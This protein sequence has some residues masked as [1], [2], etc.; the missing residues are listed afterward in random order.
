[1][2]NHLALCNVLPQSHSKGKRRCMYQ[3]VWTI[4]GGWLLAWHQRHQVHLSKIANSW[5]MVRSCNAMRVVRNRR[6]IRFKRGRYWALNYNQTMHIFTC[7]LSICTHPPAHNYNR[8]INIFIHAPTCYPST[9]SRQHSGTGAWKAATQSVVRYKPTN[10]SKC[11]SIQTGKPIDKPIS[12]SHHRE[13]IMIVI[14]IIWMSERAWDMKWVVMFLSPMA[15]G[16]WNECEEYAPPLKTNKTRWIKNISV[17][18]LLDLIFS[19]SVLLLLSLWKS[20]PCSS[21]PRR[22]G[23]CSSNRGW[24]FGSH[25]ALSHHARSDQVSSSQCTFFLLCVC[26]CVLYQRASL[27]SVVYNQRI[28]T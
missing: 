20:F 21:P 22:Y 10:R 2:H 28:V 19:L 25:S 17:S 4:K 23:L 5:V 18:S 9:S 1:M 16:P 13:R 12:L 7:T 15:H 6:S 14:M 11:G 26:V 27:S 8:T 3:V 24:C